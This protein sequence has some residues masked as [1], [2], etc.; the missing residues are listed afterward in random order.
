MEH[1]QVEL[2]TPMA[3]EKTARL[4]D[5]VPRLKALKLE[6]VEQVGVASRCHTRIVLVD[7]APASFTV[8]CG[9]ERCRHG[10]YDL[11]GDVLPRL[12][13]R[14]EAWKITR[15]CNG[16]VGTARCLR[17]AQCSVQ[18]EYRQL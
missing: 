16:R 12:K 4:R 1:L 8:S 6:I 18:A 5:V 7:Q 2:A 3:G 10:G 14:R 11:T 15:V 9:D 17:R 13:R